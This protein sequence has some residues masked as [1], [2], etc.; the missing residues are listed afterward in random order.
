MIKISE[1]RRYLVCDGGKP[2]FYL[3]DTGWESLTRLDK[4]DAELYLKD[5]ASKKFNVIQVMGLAE[6]SFQTPT[7]NGHTALIDDD[8]MK[9]S[10]DYFA[11]ADWY[12][13]RANELGLVIALLPTWGD[14]WNKSWGRGPEIFNPENARRYGQWLGA[15]YREADLIWVLGGDRFVE[16]E[17][18]MSIMRE[19]AEGL[20][21]GDG[22]VHL[23]TFHP[24]GPHSSAEWM[25]DESWLD[26]NMWQT[27]HDRNRDTY[28]AIATD[29]ALTPVKP[30]LDGEP[31]YED[32]PI[33]FNPANGY[34]NEYDVRKA[35]YLS[36]FA[37][38]CGVTYG[39]HDV[40]QFLD[41][42]WAPPITYAHMPWKEALNLPGAGQMQH[43]RSLIESRPYLSR[44]PDQA[45]IVSDVG[46]ASSRIQATRDI[47][48]RYGFVYSAAGRPFALD[49]SKMAAPPIHLYWF[50]PRTGVANAVGTVPAQK[51]TEFTPPTSGEN[52]DWVLVLD[53]ASCQFPTPGTNIYDGY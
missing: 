2:F 6:H 35:T 39:C 3:G 22:G 26:F 9:P 17:R 15:R 4:V 34:L 1:N 24:P 31:G 28:N 50:D 37:G 8:P 20:S 25:H 7:R 38:A 45:M 16:N 52:N 11:F 21:E 30:C 53:A 18:H 19:M 29:Y 44:I 46:T 47:K 33:S 10:E 41:T 42:K 40:W 51:I 27:G 48:H 13:K 5:R 36:V 12:V 32:H 43:L 23:R 14:K 49:M